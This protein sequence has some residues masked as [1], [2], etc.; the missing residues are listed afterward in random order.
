MVDWATDQEHA[1]YYLRD[2]SIKATLSLG[3]RSK[4]HPYTYMNK[5]LHPPKRSHNLVPNLARQQGTPGILERAHTPVSE[6]NPELLTVFTHASYARS[7]HLV[8]F[9]TLS[10]PVSPH[11]SL[12][13]YAVYSLH[14]IHP[15]IYIT[16]VPMPI[17]IPIPTPIPMI[18][19]QESSPTTVNKYAW[20]YYCMEIVARKDLGKI[21]DFIAFIRAPGGGRGWIR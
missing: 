12:S 10:A 19:S 3:E 2:I 7:S 20:A 18:K 17:P 15:Q 8:I 16:Y 21:F 6:Q 5:L 9:R 13:L 4:A 14:N 11:H 1:L